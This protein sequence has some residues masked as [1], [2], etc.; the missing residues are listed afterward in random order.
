MN[1]RMRLR[2]PS[3]IFTEFEKLIASP[4]PGGIV[5]VRMK[6]ALNKLGICLL[7]GTI[8]NHTSMQTSA[9]PDPPASPDQ[10]LA[11]EFDKP[12]NAELWTTVNDNVMGGR[13]KG[14]F[15]LENGIL[16]FDGSTN[17][18]GGGFSSIRTKPLGRQLP[19]TDSVVIRCKG[20]GRTYRFTARTQARF[21]NI[22]VGYYASF[23]TVK[24][25]W[26]EVRIPLDSFQAS[27]RGMDV[28]RIAPALSTQDIESIGLMIYDKK[29]GPFRLEVEW[30]KQKP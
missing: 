11:L 28:S 27:I 3:A 18:N 13:S 16:V 8:I 15:R 6:N 9:Q 12:D 14:G 10:H 26:T 5:A 7:A 19:N 23:A 29:D 20:D 22:Q 25:E 17:T 2:V 1:I 4:G 24:D 21:Q 30:I